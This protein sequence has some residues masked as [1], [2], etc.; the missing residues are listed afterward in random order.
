M[1][2]PLGPLDYLRQNFW[3]RIDQ[4]GIANTLKGVPFG[5]AWNGSLWSLFYEFLC[6]LMLAVF[7]VSGS[8]PPQ[9]RRHPCR[10]CLGG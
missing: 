1:R 4:R 9:A 10:R 3:L 7:A 8:S 5:P 2:A 6:Y